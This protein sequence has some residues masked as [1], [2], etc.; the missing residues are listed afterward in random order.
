ML[1]PF[2]RKALFQL[3]PERAH[4]FTFKQL[5]R[6]TGTPLEFLV[7]QSVASKPVTCMGLSFKNP[8]GLAAGLDKDG[9]CIDA[10]GAMGFG[11]IEVGT[12]TPRAQSGN[13]KPRLFRLVEAEGLINRMGF[14]NHG[15]DNLVE[16]VKK[17]H[18]GGVLGINIG[19]NKD[20]SV[21]QGKDDYLIC[22]EKVYS[23]AGYIAI[24][25]SSP[26]TPGL[27]TL[28]YGEALD[29]LLTA[30]KAKQIELQQKHH[31]YVPITVKIAPDLSHEEL[32]QVADSL[33][34]H[35]IDGVIATNTTL[36]RKL[37]NGFNY[38]DQ[39]G[40]LSGRPLQLHSTEIVR[41]LS[42]ELQGRLPIIGVGGIDSVI[43]A[44]E[45]IDAGASL[46]QI[47]SGFIFKGP[48]LIK[49]IVNYI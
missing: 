15:V 37:V 39:M 31:K 38:C 24:N 18:F 26:N 43:A 49:D 28:Q 12:V 22:M 27:R 29:D 20:T 23:Y 7:R 33:V 3:D 42:K 30:I 46:V 41:Q 17:S 36:D 48:G 5:R 6:I 16:N 47:Y 8:L 10:L 21:E 2:V 35:N 4:E 1:Y 40:G 9:E 32:I 34:R 45:K 19:K 14:N 11:F 25:I 13:D 44:R